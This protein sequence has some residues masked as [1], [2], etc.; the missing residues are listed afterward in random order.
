MPDARYSSR[1]PWIIAAVAGVVFVVA[2]VV[3]FVPLAHARDGAGPGQLTSDEQRAIDAAGTETAN[4]TTRSRAHYARD[5]ARALAGA[6][7]GVRSDLV[8]KKAA[9]L[10]FLTT[11]KFDLTSKVT[12][13]AL[14]GPNA[15]GNGYVVLVT[16]D[17]YK[18][19]APNTPV[20]SNLQVTVVRSGTSYLVSD[21]HSIGVA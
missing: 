14:V 19:S 12:H 13:E 21:L 20:Q 15:K 16:V 11:N 18:S 6:T 2:L 4:L 3:Y 8:A 9:T 5:Y 17:G 7:G 1:A 10:K